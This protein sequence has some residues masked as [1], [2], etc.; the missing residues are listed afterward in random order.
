MGQ[1]PGPAQVLDVGHGAVPLQLQFPAALV[2]T[3]IQV[4]EVLLGLGDQA[5]EPLDRLAFDLP[6]QQFAELHLLA[7]DQGVETDFDVLGDPLDLLEAVGRRLVYPGLERLLVEE[8]FGGL[9]MRNARAV[10]RRRCSHGAGTISCNTVGS[11]TV[12]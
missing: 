11:R 2:E 6:V 1:D 7:V 5:V 9:A 12:I 4:V 10:I 3:V 8:L